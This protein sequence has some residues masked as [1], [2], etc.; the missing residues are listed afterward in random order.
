MPITDNAENSLPETEKPT[1][2]VE[3]LARQLLDDRARRTPGNDKRPRPPGIDFDPYQC[4]A[5]VIS[6]GSAPGYLP[7]TPMRQGS[8]GFYIHCR[9]CNA[10]FESKGLAYCPTCQ[11]L[12][13]E[14]RNAMKPAFSGRM[15]QASGCERPVPRTA[16]A[17]AKFCS[18]T[19]RNRGSG[20]ARNRD[21]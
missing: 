12:P 17:G 19:C 13:A 20:R 3:K 18:K 8:A 11:E 14:E 4:G 2:R 7:K 21:R 10:E 1:S 9:A 6:A 5:W 16:R 15:C